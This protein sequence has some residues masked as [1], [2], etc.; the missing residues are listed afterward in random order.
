MARLMDVARTV[1]SKN[2]GPDF[3]T[4]D[5]IFS[6]EA[7]YR[8]VKE[9]GV[10]TAETVARGIAAAAASGAPLEV[11]VGGGGAR[12]PT[13]MRDIA[14]RLAARIE[15]TTVSVTTHEAHGVSSQAKEA[16]SFAVLAAAAIRGV[17]NTLPSCTGAAAPVVMGKILPGRNYP[18]LMSRLF[19][20][21][22][23]GRSTG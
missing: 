1:R 3:I 21:P 22:G 8:E 12:N 18:S 9:S 23:P 16:L 14:R 2:A 5:I 10:L 4:F 15:G 11:I 7:V 19:G 6:D 20:L 17:P 13:L